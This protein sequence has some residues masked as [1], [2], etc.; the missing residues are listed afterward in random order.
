MKNPSGWMLAAGLL[1]AVMTGP[2]QSQSITIVSRSSQ[3]SL[4]V[5]QMTDAEFV[6]LM[7]KHHED[8]IAMAKILKERGSSDSVKALAAGIRDI[9]EQELEQLKRLAEQ[10]GEPKDRAGLAEYAQTMTEQGQ[11]MIR[12]L[13]EAP[14]GEAVDQAFLEE[15]ARHHQMGIE[16]I[17]GTRF[18]NGALR[19]LA[20]NMEKE[21]QAEIRELKALKGTS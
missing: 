11:S 7:I 5:R 2:A 12:R 14:E 3:P 16:L 10:V 20:R 18:R 4:L 9:Q 1:G 15:M 8:G 21:Q 6:P 17:A 13:E 19:T